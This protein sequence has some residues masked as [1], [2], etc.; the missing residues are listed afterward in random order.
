MPKKGQKLGQAPALS[1]RMWRQWLQF[2]GETCGA[3]MQVILAITGFFGLRTGEAVALKVEDVNLSADV[4]KLCVTGAVK[5]AKKS[6]G[7]VYVR[8]QHLAWM[9]KLMTHG[10]SVERT[11]K[12]KHGQGRRKTVTFE[13]TYKPPEQGWMFPSRRGSRV[14]HVCYHAVYL[15]VKKAAP[16]FLKQLKEQ[17]GKHSPEIAR[18]RPHSGAVLPFSL[19]WCLAYVFE[20]WHYCL[21]IQDEPPL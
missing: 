3:R 4:P 10:I 7:E 5:G 21:L 19:A 6:P 18:L 2:V 16:L 20:K 15:Q 8:Q 13:N 14:P 11:K 9:K 12:H 1:V 17:G